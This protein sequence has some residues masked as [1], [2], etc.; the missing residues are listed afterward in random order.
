MKAMLILAPMFLALA[1]SLPQKKQEDFGLPELHKIKTATLSSTYSCRSEEELQQGYGTTALFLSTDPRHRIGPEL[2]FD[3][4]CGERD[5]FQSVS[6]GDH[7]SVIAD[8]G[9]IPLKNVTVLR[10]FYKQKNMTPSDL[11]TKFMSRVDVQTGHTYAVLAS[12][13]DV[14]AMFVF[15]VTG[16]VPNKRVDLNYVVKEYQTLGLKAQ[17]PGFDWLTENTM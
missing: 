2:L 1:A 6:G 5:Y 15:K 7:T 14:K 12:S 8:L 9:E 3:G 4:V 16:Y 10:M 11:C 17:S 13:S